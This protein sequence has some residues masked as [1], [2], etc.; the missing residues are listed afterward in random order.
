MKFVG[1]IM[2]CS[3][4]AACSNVIP[5]ILFVTKKVYLNEVAIASGHHKK[6]IHLTLTGGNTLSLDSS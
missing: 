3:H 4:A 6:G 1:P 2:H 5:D